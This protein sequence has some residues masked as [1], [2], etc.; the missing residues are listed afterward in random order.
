MPLQLSP[1]IAGIS[2]P[3]VSE[4]PAI[5]DGRET[6][7]IAAQVAEHLKAAAQAGSRF[8]FLRGRAAEARLRMHAVVERRSLQR[9][10]VEGLDVR[11][12]LNDT[13]V[14]VMTVAF[15]LPGGVAV[16]VVLIG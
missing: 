8:L 11:D 3:D 12:P 14:A 9:A 13:H 16:P 1:S 15:R 7:S 2:L 10:R 6:N 4:M 5:D